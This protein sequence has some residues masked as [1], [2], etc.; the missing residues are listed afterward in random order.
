MKKY[1]AVGFLLIA[2]ISAIVVG[3]AA[4]AYALPRKSFTLEGVRRIT[5]VGNNIRSARE[6]LK[7]AGFPDQPTAQRLSPKL[8]SDAL[9]KDRFVLGSSITREG[10]AVLVRVSEV[11]PYFRMVIG[12]QRYWLCRDGE[13][14]LMDPQR[15]KG[16]LFDELRKRVTVRL[17][18]KQ[19]LEDPQQLAQ[20]VYIAMRLEET[21][22]LQ[23]AELRLGLDGK[24]DIVM[25]NGFVIQL[26][27]PDP[28]E[29]EGK[30]AVLGKA[31]RCAR[32]MKEPIKKIIFEDSTHVTAS[33]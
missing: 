19:M 7:L 6:V 10:D 32:S 11:R 26:G 21:L 2:V 5:V 15:D 20:A 18:A 17:A 23:F 24:A 1:A 13:A 30:L 33:Y 29:L 14:I 3:A 28:K 25:R 12:A 22:P 16:M 27:E 9:R 8:M 4:I 31:I